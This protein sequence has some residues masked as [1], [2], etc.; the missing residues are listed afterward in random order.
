MTKQKKHLSE[1]LG[2]IIDYNK[3]T[4][5]IE[6]EEASGKKFRISVY[7]NRMVRVHFTQE[8]DF[9]LHSYA[10]IAEP[11]GD[12][13]L[14][15]EEDYLLIKTSK[16]SVKV[17]KNPMRVT[18]LSKDN[19][20][21]NEDD[22]AFGT[23][24]IGDEVS[25]YKKLQG[26]ERFIGMGEKTG[27]LDRRGHGYQHWNTDTFAYNNDSDPLYCSTPFYIG[28][29]N[30]LSYGIYLD[31][32]HKSH[33]N[34][35]A[36]ND[37]FS[38][39]SADYGDM[40]YYLIH[41]EK[42][43]GI[44]EAYTELTGRMS[45]PPMWSIGYQQCRYS[46]Y[47]DKEVLNVARTFRDKHI[48]ADVIVLDIHYMEKFKIFSWDP[49]HFPNPEEMMKELRDKGFHIVIMCDPGIKIEEGYAPYESGKD[50]DVFIK[51]PDG[52]F[53]S[54]EVW[55]GW[56]HFPDFTSD[57]VREW[58]KN[59]LKYYSEIGVDGYW[60]DMNEIATWGQM[61]PNLIE[62]DFDGNPTTAREARNVYGFQMARSTYEGTKELLGGKR[63]F[64]LTRSGFSGV[65]R[66]SAVWTGDNVANDEHMMLGVRL[67]NSLGLAGIAF[68]GPDVGGFVGNPN[69]LVL[70]CTS[71][72]IG[73]IAEAFTK[74][75]N[76]SI[77][78]SATC[79]RAPSYTSSEK[80]SY[81]VPSGR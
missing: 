3:T 27:P 40:N 9:E 53:Y 12:F 6:G 77:G 62:F 22:K 73:I 43:A 32:S 30:K 37:R 36:S 44:L 17:D 63:P 72:H 33:F 23:M 2:E 68:T 78:H 55:P 1:T 52:T 75:G 15:E 46:Y 31:N 10:V 70:F 21:V 54:G 50:E 81:H 58:W 41:D 29:H 20:V 13:E 67:V 24:W 19:E 14:T 51:Y 7:S 48:P 64:N 59:Q 35:G 16:L 57:K 74:T 76:C 42:V 4:R 34:F 38:S 8:E 71:G 80:N 49:V 56:C 66:Y 5:G 26:G 11:Y 65:Q 39:F 47:P 45:M 18:L 25:T 69:S 61:L 79:S 60:N 28:I